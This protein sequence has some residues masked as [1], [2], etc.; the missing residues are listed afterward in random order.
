[1]NA[2]LGAISPG[3]DL[4]E[5]GF[6]S[7]TGLVNAHAGGGR[8]WTKPGK[9]FRYA[10]TGGALFTT[11]DWDGNI[12]WAGG[13]NFGYVEFKNYY[14]INWNVAYNPWTVN[15]RRTR[16]GPLTLTPPGYQFGIDAGTDSRKTLTL[17]TG[18]GTYYRSAGDVEFWSYANVQYRPAPNVSVT[19]GPNFSRS[20]N[21][22]QY[23]GASYDSTGASAATYDTAYRFARLN[24]T[25]LSAGIRL[26]WT[27]SPTLSLQLYAQPLISAGKYDAFK[28]LT[29]PRSYEFDSL[30]TPSNRGDFNFKSLRG[31]AVLRWEYLP[32]STLFFVWTQSRSDF[33]EMG[34]FQFGHSMQRLFRAPGENIFMIKATYWWNP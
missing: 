22:L 9:L 3:F 29:R 13:F 4:N 33:E 1:V 24:Q 19:V 15:N 25:E 6:I 32:G 5:L 7:R 14:W 31:N 26:N 12:N 28:K 18:A 10:E 27:Y 11:Y 8:T 30:A 16:G 17:G 21:P 2:A 20:R 34:D 23:V